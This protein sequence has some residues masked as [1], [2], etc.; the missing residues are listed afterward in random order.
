MDNT[1]KSIKRLLE[2]YTQ[3]EL[4]RALGV[5]LRSIQNYLNGSGMHKETA[6][7]MHELLEGQS[8]V[9]HSDAR[10][11]I[12]SKVIQIEA[13]QRVQLTLLQGLFAKSEGISNIEAGL[14][15]DKSLGAELQRLK[16]E[17]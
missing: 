1:A 14:I 6:R 9:I 13:M 11:L 12:T 16:E 3:E 10:G 15:I 8:P 5:S 17:L 2:K 4:S 7:K